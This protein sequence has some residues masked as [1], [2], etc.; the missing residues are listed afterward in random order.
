MSAL[1]IEVLLSNGLQELVPY[2]YIYIYIYAKNYFSNTKGHFLN[3]SFSDE[4][5]LRMRKLVI[6]LFPFF[7]PS[8][9]FLMPVGSGIREFKGEGT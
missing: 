5:I 8:H 9:V 6:L 2:T 1:R 7:L 3:A 4:V